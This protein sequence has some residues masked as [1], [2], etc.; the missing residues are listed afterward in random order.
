MLVSLRN[1]VANLTVARVEAALTTGIPFGPGG[2]GMC[3]DESCGG[4][5]FCMHVHTNPTMRGDAARR[6]VYDWKV[7]DLPMPHPPLPGATDTLRSLFTSG[8]TARDL[9][10]CGASAEMLA[11]CGVTLHNLV[12]GLGLPLRAVIED[13]ALDWRR[14]RTLSFDVSHL[15][16]R[17][18]FPLLPLMR[19]SIALSAAHVCEF[20]VTYDTLRTRLRLTT[21]E[22][23]ALGFDAPLLAYLCMRGTDLVHSLLADAAAGDLDFHARWYATHLRL[24]PALLADLFHT[25]RGDITPAE[26]AAWQALRDAVCAKSENG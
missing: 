1:A 26:H 24:A 25:T 5:R 11:L 9:A 6:A 10:R 21:S 16:D 23:V 20:P 7:H 8:S 17:A 14:L 13:L 12:V 4:P 15:E 19:S 22:L 2:G 18:A 3:E